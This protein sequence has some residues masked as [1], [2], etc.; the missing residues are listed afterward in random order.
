MLDA[1]T[2]REI[3]TYLPMQGILYKNARKSHTPI[4]AKY[5]WVN[6][7]QYTTASII[8]LYMKGEYN[9]YVKRIKKDHTKNYW[10]NF[11]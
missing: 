7:K 9:P 1:K 5:V 6:G 3:F 4:R 11:K 8:W 2:V 10:W